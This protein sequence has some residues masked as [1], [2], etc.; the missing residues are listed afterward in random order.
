MISFLELKKH[1]SHIISIFIAMLIIKET[2]CCIACQYSI[3]VVN[4]MNIEVLLSY[5]GVL[6]VH[7]CK[8]F[9]I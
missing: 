2:I 7:Q 8:H 5:E 1:L 4:L 3:D 9:H 6:Q